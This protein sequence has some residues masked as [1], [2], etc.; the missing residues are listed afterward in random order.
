MRIGIS[1][2]PTFGGSGVVATELAMALASAGD[3]VHV[4]SYA[5]PSRLALVSPNLFFH[6][7]V[8]P[9]YPL[10]EYPPYSLALA[11][12]MAEVA[13]F[14]GLDLLHV[15]YAVPNAISAILARSIV[16]PR[17]LPVVTTLH[18][19]DVT[20]I[21]NDPSYLETTRWA[22]ISSDA[23]TAV[24]EWLRK[25]TVEQL[26][27]E[28]TPI[29]VIPN[30]IE[31]E[32]FEAVRHL[33]GA[34]RWA[35]PGEKI[36]IHVS[37]FR[38]VKRVMDV[39][40]VYLR[41]RER[42]PARLLFLGDGPDRAK[43]EARCREVGCCDGVVF[44]GNHPAVEEILHGADLFL[45]P[46]AGESFGL[47][48]LEALS[49]EVP[50]IAADAGGVPEVIEEGVDGLLFPV[51]DV[52]AMARGAIELLSDPERHRAFARRGRERAVARFS[53]AAIVAR[54]RALYERVLAGEGARAAV[55]PA[56][57]PRGP[58]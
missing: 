50:V 37:N 8:V 9:H 12:K 15:H 49:C 10:F 43:V 7:V 56:G 52:D 55:V 53:E 18:G 22:V 57:A 35:K 47:A 13:R 26:C 14:Q 54:Y 44:L 27:V 31:P 39:L 41:V 34:R 28:E 29:E 40:E 24:S 42:M 23:V 5:L 19:T 1:C 58:R 48:A 51:G 36:L 4:L 20:L 11:S 17:P 38:P 16:A 30:F 25:K 33:P 32:R 6:E 46:S 21:G 45:L 3:E 2:Y